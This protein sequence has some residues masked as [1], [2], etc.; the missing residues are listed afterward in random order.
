MRCCELRVDIQRHLQSA[1]PTWLPPRGPPRSV[2]RVTSRA[3]NR[4]RRRM[5]ADP[6]AARGTPRSPRS[7]GRRRRAA[8]PDGPR[9]ASQAAPPRPQT[10]GGC[11]TT[12]PPSPWRR[13]APLHAQQPCHPRLGLN[14]HARLNGLL[15]APA[16]PPGVD[17]RP[18]EGG[19]CSSAAGARPRLPASASSAAQAGKPA[20]LFVDALTAALKFRQGPADSGRAEFPSRSRPAHWE[21]FRASCRR[22]AFG[23]IG[24]CSPAPSPRLSGLPERHG[25]C[26]PRPR[27]A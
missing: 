11:R 9:P 6:Q 3:A 22:L 8:R 7:C 12:G 13:S 16:Y 25:S 2:T 17:F 20:G 4:R 1:W 21:A 26:P 24:R 23:R 10:S 15:D 27:G 18:T 19:Q 14:D 5:P